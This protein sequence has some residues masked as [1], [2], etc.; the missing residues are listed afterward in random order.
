MANYIVLHQ[1][2]KL[3]FI[4]FQYHGKRS[5]D[6]LVSFRQTMSLSQRL[7]EVLLVRIVGEAEVFDSA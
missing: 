5:R 6:L 2:I 1:I 4:K 3:H 7:F